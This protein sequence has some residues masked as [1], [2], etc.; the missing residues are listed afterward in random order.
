MPAPPA[1]ILSLKTKQ[2]TEEVVT[3]CAYMNDWCGQH[4]FLFFLTCINLRQIPSLPRHRGQR[5]CQ[6]LSFCCRLSSELGAMG[7]VFYRL[8]N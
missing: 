4:N 5:L 8:G 7:V 1:E 3:L 6:A 2:Q